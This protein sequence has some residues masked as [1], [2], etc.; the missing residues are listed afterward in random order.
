MYVTARNC[1]GNAATGLSHPIRTTGRN[2]LM[3][4]I[5]RS[6]GLDAPECCTQCG[7]SGGSAWSSSTWQECGYYLYLPVAWTGGSPPFGPDH[8]QCQVC[9]AEWT[10]GPART[11]P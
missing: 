10:T 2:N 8:W 5:P 6:A 3:D 9:G 4:T 1:A 7:A 11:R